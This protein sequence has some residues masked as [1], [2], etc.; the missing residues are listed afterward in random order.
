[1]ASGKVAYHEARHRT[2][3]GCPIIL[4]RRSINY[5][6]VGQLFDLPA[7]TEAL[8]VSDTLSAAEDTQS[9]LEALGIDHIIYHPY[10]PGTQD[11]PQLSL[12][13][14]PGDT[15]LVPACVETIIDIKTRT[16]DIT[17]LTE[18]LHNLSMM[19]EKT[20]LLSAHFI[21]DIVRLIRESRRSSEA[22]KRASNRLQ[23]IINTV[24]DGIIAVDAE[25]RVTAFNPVAESFFSTEASLVLGKTVRELSDPHL[26]AIL[27]LRASSD[28]VILNV[29]SRHV[30]VN[31][32]SI[33]SD[34]SRPGVV[35]SFKDV[36]EIQRIEEDV[37]RK[38]A[39]KLHIARYTFDHVFGH[40]E[41][42]ARTIALA[43]RL[44]GSSA[45][46]LLQGESG[47]GKEL[48][49]QSIHN[50]SPRK[51]Q[52]FIAI[53]FAAMTE[54]LLESEL[55]GYEEGAFTGAR[56][57]GATG[58][59]EQ[60]HKG[61]LFLDEVGD[62][63]LPFQVK[64]L[65]VLQEKQV[66]RV[67]GARLIPIDVRIISASNQNLDALV[68]KGAFRRDLYYRLN[69][70]PIT[71][72]ALRERPEDILDL[73]TRFYDDYLVER[74]QTIPPAQ[75]FSRI[76]EAL[77]SCDW[78]GNIRQLQNVIEYLVNVSPDQIPLPDMLPKDIQSVAGTSRQPNRAEIGKVVLETIS[79]FNQ[80]KTTIGR[81]TLATTLNLPERVIRTVLDQLQ[82]DGLIQVSKGRKGLTLS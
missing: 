15:G 67:G 54:S 8:L 55:F 30:V 51:N 43:R 11:Y 65:R 47:T 6:E 3:L 72:P 28:E 36:S 33:P 49:A 38:L 79:V 58:L 19:D 40:S 14:T 39:G 29:K 21:R 73:A 46:I 71:V 32:A 52:P 34:D 24:H 42:M 5:H 75:Y 16:I 81:R 63:P 48:L 1:M 22:S 82:R 10:V 61:T 59:F 25:H 7:G 70:L 20:N 64:L 66:R 68:A 23:T 12:A 78:P 18:I 27:D 4:A 31:A 56:K 26:R 53:N 76:S 57:G 35:Y 44:A 80:Q 60:A 50:A 2:E 69:V 45:P 37:R 17:T 41:S 77:L 9:M 74:K 62:A 13:V